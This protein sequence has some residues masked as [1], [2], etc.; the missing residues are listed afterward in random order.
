MRI[1]SVSDALTE[2]EFIELPWSIYSRDSNWIP[3][4]RQDIRK[5]FDPEKNRLLRDGKVQRWLLVSDEGRTIGRIAAFVNPAYAA[6]MPY[7]TGGLGFFECINSRAASFKLF[8]VATEWLRSEGMKAAD[9]PINFGEK[10]MFWGLLIENFTDPPGYGLAYNPAYYKEYFEAYGF[11]VYYEQ[12]IYK[13]DL[14][15]PAQEVF[16][17]KYESIKADPDFEIRNARGVS[18]SQLSGD[19]LTV[20][21]NAWGG[22]HGFKKMKPAQADKVIKALKPVL[23]PDIVVFV[24]HQKKPVAFYIN[25]PELNEIFCFVN[26]NLNWLGKLK[27]LWHKWRKTPRT[28]V[29]IVFG[30]DRAYH[31]KGLEG[32]MVK[33]TE[34]NIVTLKRYDETVLTWIG[35]FN[36]KMIHIAENLGAELYRKMATYRLMLDDSIPYERAPI[37]Q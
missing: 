34:E 17:R 29:G 1:L 2:N 5:V 36:P 13:R 21:N 8:D 23:D 37:V 32:A 19:F 22:H 35:D 33:W 3:H 11:Q 24:Y 4:L 25:I 20:Y 15:V 9:G 12:F 14:N 31:G 6:G 16:V 27:F 18:T 28:M 7:P 30:V 26:G 10:N